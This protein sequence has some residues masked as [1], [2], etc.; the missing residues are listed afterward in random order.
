M[1]R[2]QIV[3]Y[4]LTTRKSLCF[5]GKVYFALKNLSFLIFTI[6]WH[7]QEL[8]I[9]KYLSET[10]TK[11][12]YIICETKGKPI[13]QTAQVVTFHSNTDNIL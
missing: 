9:R 8:N 1:H 6:N 12:N 5:Q 7:I 2:T 10:R 3:W 13:C 11:V 4:Q